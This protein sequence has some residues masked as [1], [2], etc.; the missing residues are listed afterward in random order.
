L[1]SVSSCLQ[2]AIAWTSPDQRNVLF[3]F[4]AGHFRNVNEFLIIPV[5][6]K[7]GRKP[8][9]SAVTLEGGGGTRQNHGGRSSSDDGSSNWR[10]ELGGIRVFSSLATATATATATTTTTTTVCHV[11][12]YEN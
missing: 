1:G 12:Q 3:L 7:S 9:F 5:V 10:G 8:L 6:S 11:G 2:W 4:I